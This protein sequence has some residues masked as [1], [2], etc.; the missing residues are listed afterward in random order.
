MAKKRTPQE[1]QQVEKETLGAFWAE[2]RRLSHQVID[3]PLNPGRAFQQRRATGPYNQLKKD[4]LKVLQ[5][6]DRRKNGPTD[7]E[8]GSPGEGEFHG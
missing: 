5:K 1:A 8:A 7:A 6:R 4:A 3:N 2:S